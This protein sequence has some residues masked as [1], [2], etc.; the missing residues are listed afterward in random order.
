MRT[1]EQNRLSSAP[2]PVRR[3][4][5][6]HLAWLDR[7]FAAINDDLARS[8]REVLSGRSRKTCS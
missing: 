2:P 8:I 6:K 1:A 4:I 3:G 7:Q 5:Q